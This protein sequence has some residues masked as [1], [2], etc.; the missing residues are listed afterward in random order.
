MKKLLLSLVVLAAMNACTTKETK[1]AEAN[2]TA[3][4]K[5]SGTFTS[6][7][8]KSAKVKELLEAYAKNDTMVGHNLYVDTVQVLDLHANNQE[9]P[10]DATKVNPGGRSGQLI[11]DTFVHTLNTSITVTTGPNAI[12]TFVFADGR[13]ITGYWGTLVGIGRYTK[14]RN[15]VPLHLLIYWEGDKI[16]KMYRMWDSA[17]LKAEIAASQKK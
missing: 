13:V 1:N 7:D 17:P 5:E 10:N 14:A 15:I 3:Q 4:D 8:E 9:G 6:L 11:G 12:K 2:S 16:V